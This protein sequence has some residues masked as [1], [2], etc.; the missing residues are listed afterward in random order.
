MRKFLPVRSREKGVMLIEALIAIL[1][2]SIGI[3]AVVGMQSVAIK[4]VTESKHRSE[5]AFLAEELLSQM[6]MDQ[7]I[8]LVPVQANTSNVTVANYNYPGSGA[9]PARLTKWVGRVNAKLPGSTQPGVMPKV[10][11]TNPT[12]WGTPPTPSG[13]TVKIEVFWQLPEEASLGLPPHNH[14]V[15]ASIQV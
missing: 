1:I 6:W 15:I 11:I 2:F 5:A 14:T 12:T 9:V 7:N 10:T 8:T 13:A 4:N 3:L